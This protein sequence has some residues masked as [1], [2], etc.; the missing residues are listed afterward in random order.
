M[1][2]LPEFVAVFARGMELADIRGPVAINARTK[3]A[4]RAGIGHSEDAT[5]RLVL[6]ELSVTK[7]QTYED[8]RIGVPY[9]KT[10]EENVFCVIASGQ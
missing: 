6:K 8:Y 7:S 10:R 2:T 5:M 1:V 9:A 4:F 3:I